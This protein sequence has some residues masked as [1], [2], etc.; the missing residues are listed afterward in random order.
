MLIHEGNVPVFEG[1]IEMRRLIGF[2]EVDFP[3]LFN[4]H[5]EVICDFRH[6]ALGD[7][8]SLRAAEASERG[9]GDRISLRETAADMHIGKLIASV[10]M[11]EC[12][13]DDR[14]AEV[15]A[16]PCVGKDV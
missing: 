4:G 11:R 10:D 6:V 7:E 14:T 16:P 5:T 8:H 2:V 3:E 9:I 1:L 12:T 13:I 15:L